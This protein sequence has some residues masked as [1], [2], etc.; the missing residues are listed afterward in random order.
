MAVVFGQSSLRATEKKYSKKLTDKDL[1]TSFF[2]LGGRRAGGKNVV[3]QKWQRPR[4]L[5]SRPDKNMEHG[6]FRLP[7]FAA[8]QPPH[9]PPLHRPLPNI[10]AELPP[11]I[12]TVAAV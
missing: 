3:F 5:F 9:P 7:I 6:G 10:L 2:I 8:Q 1:Q 4:T 11:Y 12:F